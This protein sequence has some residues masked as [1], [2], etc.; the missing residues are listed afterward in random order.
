LE[1]VVVGVRHAEKFA[2]HQGRHGQRELA[3]EVGRLGATQ[4]IVDQA[5]DDLLHGR[6]EHVHP[7][8]G[9]RRHDHPAQPGVFRVV[10]GAEAD[11]VLTSCPQARARVGVA[12]PLEVGTH[13]GIGEQGAL[14]GV[15]GD[16]PRRR[17]V[18]Q[19]DPGDGLL[20]LRYPM[21]IPIPRR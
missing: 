11:R 17:A 14:V 20:G 4:Q 15:P 9:E 8:D 2:D 5:V 1:E 3:H 16:Q 6:P 12:G 18:P 21:Y 10:H 13:P 7:L 19:P